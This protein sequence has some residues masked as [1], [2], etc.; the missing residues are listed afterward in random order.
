LPTYD[1]L[2]LRMSLSARHVLRNEQGLS[3]NDDSKHSEKELMNGK[4]EILS[5]AS[6]LFETLGKVIW[7]AFITFY[8][9]KIFLG[10]VPD[11]GDKNKRF[12]PDGGIYLL[13]RYA[14]ELVR[15]GIEEIILIVEDKL[16]GSNDIRFKE[17][18][19]KQ[20]TGNAIERLGK[21]FRQAE[22][23]FLA[24]FYALVVFVSGC[25][26][27]HT[28]TISNRLSMMNYFA[29]NH[30]VS[31]SS[32]EEHSIQEQIDQILPNINVLKKIGPD[33]KCVA[34]IFVKAH[35]WDEM[36]HGSSRWKKDE[37]VLICCR[38]LDRVH[39]VIAKRSDT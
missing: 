30:Y 8:E 39:E 9:L 14:I 10:L 36:D 15:N 32:I 31:V 7:K 16:Q 18:K 2:S 12:I 13:V 27:H 4:P 34:S 17:K 35:K 20:A 38:T 24:E 22:M 5:Y 19:P 6:Q 11:D 29:P 1:L 3:L 28:E 23:C 37:I 26:L 21:T 33:R 25:D